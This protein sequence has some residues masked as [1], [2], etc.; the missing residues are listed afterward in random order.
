MNVI[1]DGPKA[2]YDLDFNLETTSIAI[3]FREPCFLGAAVGGDASRFAAAAFSSAKGVGT[4]I[5]DADALS[6]GLLRLYYSAFYAGHATLRFLGRSCSY[7]ESA[8]VMK[9]RRLATAFGNPPP[10]PIS[11]GLYAC[12]LNGAQTGFKFV[13]ARGRVG[14]AHEAFW[15]VFDEFLSETTEDVLSNRIA[16]ADARDV[17]LKLEGL[18]RLMARGSGASW[19]SAMR[20]QIQYQH[21]LGVW[22]PPT[23]DRTKRGVLY[24]IA[25]QWLR[26]PMEIELDV[27]AGGE[28]GAFV[29]ACTFIIALCR[30]IL[31][32]VAEGSTAGVKSFARPALALC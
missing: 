13:H 15:E 32:R 11:A 14:G 12:T 22:A 26:D 4:A 1:L 17:F 8:H 30:V 20:N 6:W 25:D 31:G 19:L 9:I 24:R 21:A 28:L 3:D 2:G 10:F 7:L 5:N 27:P 18:R 29:S 23:I 16:P